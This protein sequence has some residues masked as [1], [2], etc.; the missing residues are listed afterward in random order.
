MFINDSLNSRHK[1][2]L[3]KLRLKAVDKRIEEAISDY[4][5]LE[6]SDCLFS[7]Q[8]PHSCSFNVYF[9]F[10]TAYS[11]DHYCLTNTT[12][13]QHSVGTMKIQMLLTPIDPCSLHVPLSSSADSTGTYG[14]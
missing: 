3:F 6:S 11:L 9:S 7:H 8:L 4:N 1:D 13:A 14:M 5:A 2:R 10:T 12:V